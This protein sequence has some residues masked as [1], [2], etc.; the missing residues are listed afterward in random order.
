MNSVVVA[1]PVAIPVVASAIIPAIVIG[2]AA[3]VL[4]A[5][6]AAP[7]YRVHLHE[8]SVVVDMNVVAHTPLAGVEAVGQRR[9]FKA[10]VVI[11]APLQCLLR[12][13]NGVDLLHNRARIAC[14]A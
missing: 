5:V 1:W 14:G 4:V 8:I 12:L 13:V 10:D 2:T 9:S 11:P 6:V 3:R 7:T